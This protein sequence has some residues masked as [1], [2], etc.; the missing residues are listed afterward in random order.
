LPG[1]GIDVESP[2]RVRQKTAH[3]V[4][5]QEI[6]PFNALPETPTMRWA[7]RNSPV[8]RGAIGASKTAFI[9]FWRIIF[10]KINKLP[11]RDMPP[12]ILRLER[13]VISMDV[14]ISSSPA[15]QNTAKP[16]CRNFQSVR[17]VHLSE[18]LVELALAR[19]QQDNRALPKS[20]LLI[21]GEW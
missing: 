18:F 15:R 8:T 4:E 12:K 16:G 7:R 17:Y 5:P 13:E 1:E 10:V 20:K 19:L 2:P 6:A 3:P 11:V 14:E 21:S 9:E